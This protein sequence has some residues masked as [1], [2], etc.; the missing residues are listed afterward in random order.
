MAKTAQVEVRSGRVKAPAS[1]VPSSTMLVPETT[2]GKSLRRICLGT[3][4]KMISKKQHT[5]TVP[6]ILPY[7]RGIQRQKVHLLN[8]GCC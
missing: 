1:E 3:K 5:M 8:D 4:E 7:A 6:S 2:G